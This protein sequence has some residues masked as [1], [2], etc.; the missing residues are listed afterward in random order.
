MAKKICY[1]GLGSNLGERRKTLRAAIESIKKIAGVC[2]LDVSSFFESEAW[3]FT[4]QPNF[5]NAAIKISCELEPLELLDKLQAVEKFFGRVREKHWGPRTLD[6]DILLIDNMKIS[7]ERLT[8][9][10]PYLSERDFVL[11]PLAEIIPNNNFIFHGDDVKKTFG[12]PRDYK[13]K[14]V[15]CVDKN[16]G[17]GLNGELLFKIPADLKHFRELTLNHTI[18]FG[19]KTLKT[20]P[21]G[22]PLDK[23]RNITLSGMDFKIDNAEVVHNIEELFETLSPNEENFVVGGG[24]TFSELLPYTREIFLTAVNKKV[25]A[26]VFLPNFEENFNLTDVKKF[27]CDMEFEFRKYE[28]C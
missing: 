17:L 21:N 4:E 27:N 28:R 20:F 9:P 5:I 22:K 8:I 11:R 14:I 18:I 7:S 2:L 23:R 15:A 16:F 24:K 25:Q 19:R 1:L 13:L 3:G 6:I 10:H 26:D 12:S